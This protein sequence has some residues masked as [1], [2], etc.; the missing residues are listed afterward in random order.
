M[1]LLVSA[2]SALAAASIRFVHA[3]PGAGAAT[4]NISVDGAGVSSSPVS[5]GKVSDPLEVA[6]GDAKLTLAPAEGGDGLA[7]ASETIA[8]GAKY[9]V[10]ALPKKDGKGAELKLFRDEKPQA[11]KA[12]FR[13][14]H[15][16]PE[17]G[18]PD[19]RVGSRVVSEKLAY[20]TATDYSD[21]PPGTQDV[22]IT[23]AGGEGGPLATKPGVELSAGTAVT[24]IV[25]GS[26]GEPTRI[27]T[28]SDG[29]AAPAG[30][31]ATG[32]GGL[33][34]SDDGGA[35]SRLA[36]A[37]LFALVAAAMGAACWSLAGRR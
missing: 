1:L 14:I 12:R 31:P 36:L 33:A 5:F 21:V 8:N 7:E 2:G 26:G 30:A 18:A 16:G 9:T 34:A 37:L 32:F 35:P 6:A 15:A 27:L 23:R 3:V 17:L 10:V 20:G 28:I 29:T 4:L 24:A 13:A 11:G 25:V 22:S 19:V